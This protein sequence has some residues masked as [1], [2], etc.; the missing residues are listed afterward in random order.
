M[1]GKRGGESSWSMNCVRRRYVAMFLG[2][3]KHKR[4]G[5]L[6]TFGNE[7]RDCGGCRIG[8]GTAGLEVELPNWMWNLTSEMGFPL[9]IRHSPG[10]P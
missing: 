7:L 5:Q 8:N 6:A 4:S 3:M 1:A 10:N 2:V 9:P